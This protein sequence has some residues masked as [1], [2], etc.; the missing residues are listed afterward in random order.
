MTSLSP[1]TIWDD[2]A[3]ERRGLADE[4]E[5]LTDEQWAQNRLC[6]GWTV[7]ETAAH[8]TMTFHFSMPKFMLKAATSGGFSGASFK[9]AQSEA[10]A[11]STSDIV[12]ELRSNAEHRFTPPGLGPEAPLADIVMHGQDILRPLGIKR[13]IPQ[14]V[15]RPILDL[16][17]SKKGKFARPKGGLDGLRFDATDIEWTSGTGPT[18]SGHSEALLMSMGG[19]TAALDDLEGDGLEAF[20]SR[21]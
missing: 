18:V 2:I 11:R 17:A 13:E 7:K 3:D 5:D 21:F 15:A 14:H 12:E 4:L 8:V 20:R 9:I 16:L 1:M 19:R 6:E 10:S